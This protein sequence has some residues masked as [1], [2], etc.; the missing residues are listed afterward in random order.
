MNC[1][2][3]NFVGFGVCDVE[4]SRNIIYPAKTPHSSD[5]RR[6]LAIVNLGLLWIYLLLE[7]AFPVVDTVLRPLFQ[8]FPLFLMRGAPMLLTNNPH[9]HTSPRPS[10]PVPSSW[11]KFLTVFST[12]TGG[13]DLDSF[14][15]KHAG[16]LIQLETKVH[17][18]FTITGGPS[19]GCFHIQ[20]SIKTLNWH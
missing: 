14:G 11:F 17:K 3:E 15:A 19:P 6:S 12:G 9:W 7:D 18:V 10:S 13:K 20:E 5:Q 2:R 1:S 8:S 16:W 4:T